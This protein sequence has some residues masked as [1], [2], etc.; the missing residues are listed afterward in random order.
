M[1]DPVEYSSTVHSKVQEMSQ[2]NVLRDD[3]FMT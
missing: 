1:N 2:I 3:N